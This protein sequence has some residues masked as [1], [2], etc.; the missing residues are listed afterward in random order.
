MTTTVHVTVTPLSIEPE[1][2]RFYAAQL[3]DVL[4]SLPKTEANFPAVMQIDMIRFSMLGG[5]PET[6]EMLVL[7]EVWA[8]NIL[9][10]V[11]WEHEDFVAARAD[12]VDLCDLVNCPEFQ[13]E[14]AMAA[15]NGEP[16]SYC[17]FG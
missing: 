14:A 16:L 1:T 6:L 10:G 12:G 2:G 13:A 5:Q 4:V 7:P 15:M 11:G 8:A 17:P 9:L 3:L